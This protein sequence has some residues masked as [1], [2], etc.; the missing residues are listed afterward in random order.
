[1][2]RRPWSC[3][4]LVWFHL[5]RLRAAGGSQGEGTPGLQLPHVSYIDEDSQE[6]HLSP[7]ASC[8]QSPSPTFS[9]SGAASME[10][11]NWSCPA[12]LFLL[13]PGPPSLPCSLYSLLA[14]AAPK[15]LPP[16]LRKTFPWKCRS[17]TRTVSMHLPQSPDSPMNPPTRCAPLQ[18]GCV[19]GGGWGKVLPAGPAPGQAKA[20]DGDAHLLFLLAGQVRRAHIYIYQKSILHRDWYILVNKH[21]ILQRYNTELSFTKN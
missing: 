10:L 1:M 5:R 6:G 8:K 18:R 3:C 11:G 16:P 13:S 12:A 7:F 21:C 20:Q 2:G 14:T 19:Q 17:K 15:C 9:P 4:G